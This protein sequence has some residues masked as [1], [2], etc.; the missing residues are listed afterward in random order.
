MSDLAQMLAVILIG[1][2]ALAYLLRRG[3]RRL[4]PPATQKQDG[5]GTCS[6]CSGGGGCGSAGR[7]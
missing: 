7:R 5:C 2:G 6:G 3:L 4:R 1:A